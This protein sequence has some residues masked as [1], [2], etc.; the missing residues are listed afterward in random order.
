MRAD[1]RH[2]GEELDLLI[3]GRLVPERRSQV[4]AHI[5]GCGRC[6]RELD[7]L[8]SAK[9]ALQDRLREREVPPTL[10]ARVTA[11]L[12]RV[13]RESGAR[14]RP[15]QVV[16]GLA[17]GLGI[18]AAAV[19]A[20]LLLRA[21]REDIIAA[22]AED[23]ARVSDA[24]LPLDLE[25]TDPTALERHFAQ[26][27]LPF[28][29]RVFDFGMMGYQLLG[30]R[31][32]R[33]EGRPSALFAYRGEDGRII[34]CQMYEGWLEELPVAV[35]ERENDGI[36]FRIYRVGDT[37]L[38]FWQEGTVVCVLTSY[39]DPEEAIQLAFAKA[40]RVQAPA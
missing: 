17:V 19:L 35:E 29:A 5:A 8:R 36:R 38:V 21:P 33:V 1:D 34:V 20:F 30:G 6:R 4:E 14:A 25:T 37:T 28:A 40:I 12:D 3:D 22:A 10:P 18:A 24:E 32:D 23:L 16:R 15:R 2:L 27:D 13:D 39:G 7:S 11:A 26:S 31:V 9:A